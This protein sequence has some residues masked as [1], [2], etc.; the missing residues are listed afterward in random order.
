MALENHE[1]F[2]KESLV[3][4]ANNDRY[5]DWLMAEVSNTI[6]RAPRLLNHDI[7][8]S[9]S[10]RGLPYSLDRYPTW[11]DKNVA[12]AIQNTAQ[13]PPDEIFMGT[14]DFLILS[15][16]FLKKC[17]VDYVICLC[18]FGEVFRHAA[19]HS[20]RYIKLAASSSTRAYACA[21]C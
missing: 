17:Q 5:P 6:S 20:M 7:H 12:E 8:T 11:I 19:R 3:R 2:L 9:N 18:K 13:P 4:L 16:A 14:A 10:S 15:P 21:P 1:D